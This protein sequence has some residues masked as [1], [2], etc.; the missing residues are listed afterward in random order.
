MTAKNSRIAFK[1][2][3][4]GSKADAKFLNAKF[5]SISNLR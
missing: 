5:S 2:L 3:R 4:R 1:V